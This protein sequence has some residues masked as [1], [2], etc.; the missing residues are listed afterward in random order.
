MAPDSRP[1]RRRLDPTVGKA[2][3]M[4]GALLGLKTTG[5][6]R[7][8][9]NPPLILVGCSGGPDSL[10]LA[11]VCAFFARRGEVRVGAVVVDHQMQDGSAEVARNTAAQLRELGLDPVLVRTVELD[12]D[13]VGPEAAA[14]AARFGALEAAAL[15]V[16]ASNVLL[17]HTLDDQA[18]SVLLGLAR[19]SG[20]RSLAGMRERRGIYLRPFL[21]LRREETL[22]ICDALE[23]QPW[24]DPANQDPAYLRVRVRHGV[25]PFLQ[26]ELGPGIA[27]SLARSAGILGRDADFLDELAAAEYGKLA[28]RGGAAGAAGAENTGEK[29]DLGQIWL[30]EAALRG[31]AP[32]LRM[33]VLALAAVELGGVQPSLERL[34]AA[35]KLLAREGSAGP[36]QLAGK[37]AVYRQSRNQAGPHEGPGYGKLVLRR[38]T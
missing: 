13:G 10:A 26:D 27:E 8:V 16:G 9:E 31:L 23:L 21:G 37:V 30:P 6:N 32:A 18:E 12:Y 5:K 29:G 38:N 1:V 22:E 35:E 15:E 11:A 20:T 2:R 14:R 17:G 25:I 7:V 19:G 24:H 28:E 33:R 36:V 3:A 34:A 4:V